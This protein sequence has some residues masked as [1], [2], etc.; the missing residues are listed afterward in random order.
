MRRTIGLATLVLISGPVLSSAADVSPPPGYRLV[1]ADEFDRPGPPDPANWTHEIGHV[2]G[3]APQIY[4]DSLDNA[5]VEDGHLVIE[6]RE[7]P[8]HPGQYTSASLTTARKQ[9][10]AYG[11]IEVR[12]KLPTAP[13][14][15][16]AIW[17]LGENH[18]RA[19]VGWPLCGEIDIMELYGAHDPH[20]DEATLHFAR[21]GKHQTAG[22]AIHVDD[23]SAYHVYATE[24]TPKQL[25]FLLDGRPFK[26]VDLDK[27]GADGDAFRGPEYL[28][29][30]LALDDKRK[31]IEAKTL[32]MQMWVDWARVYEKQ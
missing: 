27:L 15:W 5:R 13:G 9:A 7:N 30:N 2:R 26:T 3:H 22:G 10:W 4:T 16:P 19:H 20:R 29:L 17:M 11:L 25:T 32:P 8:T 14:S 6:A 24:W 12:A 31:P 18:V 28:L 21:A 1:W 23:A